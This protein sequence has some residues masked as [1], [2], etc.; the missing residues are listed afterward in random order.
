MK[1]NEYLNLISMREK[2]LE[3]RV[4]KENKFIKKMF[5]NQQYSPRTYS[6]KKE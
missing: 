1:N 3:Y 5:K 6:S 4:E 2:A